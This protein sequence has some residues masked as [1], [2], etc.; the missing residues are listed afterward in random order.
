MNDISVWIWKE[1]AVGYLNVLSR[2]SPGG[3]DENNDEHQT[4]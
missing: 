2:N 3:T 4:R 1:D